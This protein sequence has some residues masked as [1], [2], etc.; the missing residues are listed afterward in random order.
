MFAQ[1]IVD[2]ANSGVDR[3]FTYR[4]EDN[5]ILGQRVLVP[6]GS[7]NKPIEGYVLGISESYEGNI[8]LKS[9]IRPLEPYSVLTHEQIRLA[10]WIKQ[11]YNCLL[12]DALRL[13]IP[14]QLRRGRV[15]EKRVRTVKL[16]DGVDP[17]LIRAG[18]L[19]KDGSPKSPKQKEVFDLLSESNAEMSTADIC[20][21]IPGASSAIKALIDKGYITE[22]GRETYR[23]PYA[24]RIPPRTMP[25]TLSAA[26]ADVLEKISAAMDR[27]EGTMLLHGVTGSGKTEVYMQAIAKVLDE[28]G[29]AIVLV[30]E[31][32]LTPQAMDRFRGRFGEQ[33]AVLHSRLSPGERY[34]EWR[35][36]RLGKARVVLGARSAVFA[37]LENIR[38][39][40]VDEEHEQSYSSEMTPRYSAIEVAQK[41][42][43]LN[44]GVLLLGSATPSVT[45][46]FRAKRGRYALLEL[47]ERIND[48]PLPKVDI[49][50]MRQE[51]AAGNT[52]IFSGRLYHELKA[53][54]DRNEQAILFIN[55][56][57]Y[58]TFVSCRSCGYVFK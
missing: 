37:P 34:D 41:R 51:F 28:G 57:G 10:Y 16:A 47:P 36:I 11:S 18:M 24:G 52:G 2:I 58:S 3:L 1:V 49:V 42:C 29:S 35:R 43:K 23:D 55:R 27:R 32:S 48:L 4:A 5:I 9:I 13:M 39:I 40:V 6:F 14:A 46:Y 20:A 50:D 54:L 26:Q 31:I 22:A 7:G 12:V 45:S 53:C 44:G 30:P 15:K 21:F 8:A 33:V 56:R 38:L 25:L 19:K 17:Q